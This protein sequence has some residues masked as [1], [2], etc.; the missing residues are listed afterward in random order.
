VNVPQ[1]EGLIIPCFFAVFKITREEGKKHDGK[2]RGNVGCLCN[3]NGKHV[4]TKQRKK[5]NNE[6]KTTNKIMTYNNDMKVW[7]LGITV[8]VQDAKNS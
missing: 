8:C 2:K 3:G 5:I 1:I 6:T 7:P 4:K